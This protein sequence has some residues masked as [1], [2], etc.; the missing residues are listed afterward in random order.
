M[1]TNLLAVPPPGQ[2]RLDQYLQQL[3]A[4]LADDEEL[5]KRRAFLKLALGTLGER[6]RDILIARRLKEE[7][8]SLHDLSQRYSISREHVRQIEVAAYEKVKSATQRA[9]AQ[10]GLL[11]LPA[12]SAPP[13]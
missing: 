8:A 3:R 6:E 5:V 10:G 12:C 4:R 1:T 9:V 13:E 2:D 7:R 11:H